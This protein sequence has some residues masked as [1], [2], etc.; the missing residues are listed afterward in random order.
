MNEK[1]RVFLMGLS[2][3]DM[4]TRI[5]QLNLSDKSLNFLCQGIALENE[6]YEICAAVEIIKKERAVNSKNANLEIDNQIKPNKI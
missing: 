1:L 3:E 2:N 5:R 6:D 4:L